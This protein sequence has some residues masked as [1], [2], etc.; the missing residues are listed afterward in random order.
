MLIPKFETL[1]FDKLLGRERGT[2]AAHD[3]RINP[4]TSLGHAG[5]R[6]AFAIKANP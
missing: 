5:C 2:F 1:G 4:A 6:K 3:V